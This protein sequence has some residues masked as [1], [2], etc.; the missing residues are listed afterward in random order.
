[1][2]NIFWVLLY[3]RYIFFNRKSFKKKFTVNGRK[4]PRQYRVRHFSDNLFQGFSQDRAKLIF[5]FCHYH[6]LWNGRLADGAMSCVHVER[7]HLDMTIR[8]N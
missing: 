8:C 4:D 6:F 3:S 1:M 2:M 7:K 5:M